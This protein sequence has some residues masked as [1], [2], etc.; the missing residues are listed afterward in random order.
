MNT[1]I[2]IENDDAP[3]TYVKESSIEGLGLFAAIDFKK[4]DLVVDYLKFPNDWYR[5]KFE[6]LTQEQIRKNWYNMRQIFKI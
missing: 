1:S 3:F 5:M 6:D 4:G 2:F